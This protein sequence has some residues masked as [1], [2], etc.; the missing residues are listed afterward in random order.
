ML[1]VTELRKILKEMPKDEIIKLMTESY[2]R[3]KE[4]QTFLNIKFNRLGFFMTSTISI[5]PF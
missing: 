4:V 5:I 2:K 3:S 1:K